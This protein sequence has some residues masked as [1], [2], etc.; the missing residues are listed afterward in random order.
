MSQIYQNLPPTNGKV[1]AACRCECFARAMW[2]R[3]LLW[4]LDAR[5]VETQ[6]ALGACARPAL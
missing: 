6:G 3:L 5:G 2:G 4:S 1:S